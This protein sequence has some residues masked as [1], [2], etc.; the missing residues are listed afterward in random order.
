MTNTLSGVLGFCEEPVVLM[1]D[2]ESMFY[3]VKVPKHNEDLL[4]F[5]WFTEAVQEFRRT[6]HLFG[7]TS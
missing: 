5:L 2:I 6:V 1:A 7:G 3:Q 4:D